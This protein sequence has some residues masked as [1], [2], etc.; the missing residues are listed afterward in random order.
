MTLLKPAGN[1]QS[2]PAKGRSEG[3]AR[4]NG[5]FFNTIGQKQSFD[6]LAGAREQ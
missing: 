3:F 4:L 6:Q 2:W 1:D 5:D